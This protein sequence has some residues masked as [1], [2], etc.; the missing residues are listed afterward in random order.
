[1]NRSDTEPK[2]ASGVAVTNSVTTGLSSPRLMIA[3]TVWLMLVVPSVALFV[4]SLFVTYQQVQSGAISAQEHQMLSAVGLS[5]SGFN[6]LN[7]IFNVLTSAIWYMVGFL[8]FWRRSDDW[9]ALLAAFVLVMFNVS[10]YSNNNTPSVLALAYPALALPLSLMGFLADSSLGMFMLL[11]PGGRLVPRWMG[12]ILLLFLILTFLGDFPSPSSAFAANW[13]TWLAPPISLVIYGAIIYSQIYRYRRVS[14]PAQRQQ[15][16]WVILGLAVAITVIIGIIAL[17]NLTPSSSTSPF[18]EFIVTVIIWPAALLLIPLSIGFSILRYRLYDID[19]LINRTLVYGSLTAILALLYVGLI[20]ALQFL[21]QGV[22]KQNNN[23]AIVVSTLAIAAL[24]QP[25]RRRIQRII[26]RRFY[27]RKYDAART[28][29]QFSATLRNEVD[30]TELSERLITVVEE[31][32]QPAH[33]SL[34]LHPTQSD[35]KRHVAWT[36]NPPPSS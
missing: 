3:R 24:F 5:V 15:T 34:W 9:L 25:L 11:F 13:P 21:L 10:S 2:N 30:L 36:G 19:V 23:V 22:F 16:K 17:I 33:V 18:V 35:D 29:A 8:I 4:V 1:M 14:T 27:R 7:T 20:F 31:T 28:L 32:M 6:T 26:D 12:L